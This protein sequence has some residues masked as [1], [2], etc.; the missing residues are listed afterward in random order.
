MDVYE[1]IYTTRAMRR[2]SPEPLPVDLLP[3]LFDAAVRGPSGG[4]EQRFR[5]L[6]VADPGTKSEIQRIYRACLDELNATQY[7]AAQERVSSGD[8][9]DP[10]VQQTIRIDSSAQWF[11][12]NLDQSPVLIF[13]FGKPGGETTTFPCLWNLCLAA[14]AEGL[15]TAITTLL[16]LRKERV[17][18]LLGVPDDGVWHM[19]GMVPLG[20][21]TG[22]WGVARRRPAHRAVYAERWGQDVDWVVDEPL[23]PADPASD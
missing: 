7:A 6:T 22:T 14:R 13:V 11:A 8:R 2:L 9:D 19:H 12:D 1:A 16:K 5:F 18:R 20:Y 17:E 3:R 4:N 21:P 10:E 15:G 23:W